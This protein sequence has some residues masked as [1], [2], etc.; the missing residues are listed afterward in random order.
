MRS[1]YWLHWRS[2][3][4]WLCAS[5][6]QIAF[7]CSV[8]QY[9]KTHSV[10][11]PTKQFTHGSDWRLYKMAT[12]LQLVSSHLL[13]NFCTVCDPES[14]WVQAVPAHHFIMKQLRYSVF[15]LQNRGWKSSKLFAKCDSVLVLVCG[16]VGGGGVTVEH[17]FA[18]FGE[19]TGVVLVA[20]SALCLRGRNSALFLVCSSLIYS[21][22]PAPPPLCTSHPLFLLHSSSYPLISFSSSHYFKPSSHNEWNVFAACSLE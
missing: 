1:R 3:I 11:K 22:V 21:H 12:F 14:A 13:I 5:W 18:W 19:K 6:L 20:L 10:N 16:C 2:E 7:I 8:T 15:S 4:T 17:C 9:F